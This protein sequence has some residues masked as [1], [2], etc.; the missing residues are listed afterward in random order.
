MGTLTKERLCIGD[1]KKVQTCFEHERRTC[2]LSSFVH[3][4]SGHPTMLIP[5][6]KK[7]YTSWRVGLV[8]FFCPRFVS[9]TR[10]ILPFF[11]RGVGRRGGEQNWV[12]ASC[13][14][15]AAEAPGEE[16]NGLG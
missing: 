8:D 9:V 14:A 10:P 16:E 4:K 5:A 2:Q 7:N 6:R 12:V 15:E 13:V 11:P 1:K 3:T